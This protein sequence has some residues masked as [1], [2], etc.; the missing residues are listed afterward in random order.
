MHFGLAT[1]DEIAAELASRLRAQRLAQ[2]LPQNEL[3]ARAG[4]SL[5]TLTTFEQSGKVSFDIFLRIVGA[6]GLSESLSSLFEQKQLSI[7][8]MELAENQRKR[9]S[10]RHA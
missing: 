4:I 7:R 5:K 9:A 3:A 2:N 10:R 1:S 8:E 6:L